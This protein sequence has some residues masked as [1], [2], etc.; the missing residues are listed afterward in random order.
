MGRIARYIDALSEDA[1][2]RVLTAQEWCAEA[3]VSKSGARCL[4]GHGSDARLDRGITRWNAP[5]T[6]PFPEEASA[7]LRFDAIATRHGLPRAV[8][9]VKARAG[10]RTRVPVEPEPA[11]ATT[12]P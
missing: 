12:T 10:K 2:D 7:A 4:I 5:P 8:A 9:L 11:T 1:L 6:L 3:T